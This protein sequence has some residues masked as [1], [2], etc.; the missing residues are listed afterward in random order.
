MKGD[1]A[2]EHHLASVE[3]QLRG[4]KLAKEDSLCHEKMT[5]VERG[6]LREHR[7]VHAR[8]WNLLTDLVPEQIPH[9]N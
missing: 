8:E 6:W 3:Q 1:Q 7:S 4:S 5:Q 9:A 2:K